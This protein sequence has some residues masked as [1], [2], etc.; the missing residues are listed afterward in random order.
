VYNQ[1]TDSLSLIIQNEQE[2]IISYFPHF[3]SKFEIL[4]QRYNEYKD[5]MN[6]YKN[7]FNN[8]MSLDRKSFA[9]MVNEKIPNVIKPFMFQLYLKQTNGIDEYIQKQ[10]D[11][12]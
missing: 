6:I 3:R 10:I 7:I 9:L 11:G 5:T 1:C 4:E 8:Y 2:E 12:I